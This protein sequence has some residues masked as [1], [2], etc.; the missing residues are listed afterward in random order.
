M[1]MVDA[2]EGVSGQQSGNTNAKVAGG[3]MQA[4][5]EHPGGLAGVMDQ[6]RQNGMGD[7]AQ[8]WSSG[9]GQA[10]TPAQVQQ[11]LA[12]TNLLD[13]VAAKAGVSPEMA[14]MAMAVVLPMVMSHFTQGGQQPPPQGGFSG[15]ASQ[16]LSK[17]S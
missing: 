14:N 3:L 10:A 11:G 2:I 15:M 4:L 8:N 13:N 17:F 9:Q 12:G 16:I 1:G 7:H 6:F 5:D